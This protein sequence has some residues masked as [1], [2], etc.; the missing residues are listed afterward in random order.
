MAWLI[1]NHDGALLVTMNTN[2]V[3]KQN[4][5]FFADL[6]ACFDTLDR[7]HPMVP[8]V[9]TGQGR[10]FSAGLDFEEVFGFFE[11]ATIAETSAWFA[12]YYKTISRVLVADRMVVGAING[13][14][15]AGGAVLTLACD[16]RIGPLEGARASLNEVPIGIPMPCPYVE[17]A[18]SRMGDREAQEWILFGREYA[19]TEA[20][21]S[22]FFHQLAPN[23]KLLDVALSKARSIPP[24]ARAA[25]VASKKALL[26]PLLDQIERMT[27]HVEKFALPALLSDDGKA[28]RAQVKAKLASKKR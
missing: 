7:E 20:L 12:R 21:A 25:Y 23:D 1:Q 5:A 17:L 16:H 18:R 9:L 26:C 10:V 15:Y 22:G 2:P 19:P 27:P 11:R 28:A 24:L 13:H 6:H 3:N 14:A 4:E 8:I